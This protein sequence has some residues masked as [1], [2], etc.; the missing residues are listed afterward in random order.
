MKINGIIRLSKYHKKMYEKIQSMVFFQPRLSNFLHEE[1]SAA[2]PSESWQGDS[3]LLGS[4]VVT[5]QR[6]AGISAT[7]PTFWHSVTYLPTTCYSFLNSCR[8]NQTCGQSE[9]SFISFGSIKCWIIT[10]V[11]RLVTSHSH[12]YYLKL[13]VVH[14]FITFV[15]DILITKKIR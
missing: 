8:K 4:F 11:Y 10:Y 9:F 14:S 1:E 3:A 12:F 15:L 13:A 5:L 7:I 6:L 2:G